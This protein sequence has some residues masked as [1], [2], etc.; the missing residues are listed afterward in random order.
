MCVC[1]HVSVC[2]EKLYVGILALLDPQVCHH[3]LSAVEVGSLECVSLLVDHGA[4]VNCQNFNQTTPLH[5]AA[6]KGK[7]GIVEYLLEH[8]ARLDITEDYNITPIFTAAH[9]GYPK[10]LHLML[11]AAEKRGNILGSGDSNIK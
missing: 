4:D 11:K 3:F 1:V 8:G 5:R 9:C 10:C 6:S 7:A 2:V